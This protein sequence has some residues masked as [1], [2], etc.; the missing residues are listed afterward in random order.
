MNVEREEHRVNARGVGLASLRIALGFV[1]FWAFIDKLFGLG[2]STPASRAWINGGN[3]TL[4]FLSNAEGPFA[5]FFHA[6]AGHP[7]TNVL[8]MV[9][10]AA[11][12]G[13]LLLG[14]G[15]RIASYSG[16]LMLFLMYLASLPLDTNPVIDDHIV[17]AIILLLL[18]ILK[19]G[20][21]AGLGARWKETPA[22]KRYPIL[23]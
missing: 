13:A 17:Y 11:I 4:G 16:A 10:L 5:G 3:P 15:M 1:F 12:G 6:I 7:V 19:A 22:V 8:F 20:E 18:P 9:G 14:I 21:H 23:E 2:F